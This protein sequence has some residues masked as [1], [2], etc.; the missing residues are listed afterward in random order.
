MYRLQ[1]TLFGW[2]VLLLFIFLKT[3]FVIYDSKCVEQG[4]VPPKFGGYVRSIA[5]QARQLGDTEDPVVCVEHESMKILI[6]DQND[7]MT[8]AIFK[9]K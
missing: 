2:F 7:E 8:V 6:M 3:N 9:S 4:K 5:I 1:W